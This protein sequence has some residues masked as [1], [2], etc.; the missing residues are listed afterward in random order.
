M[1]QGRTIDKVK[2]FKGSSVVPGLTEPW[3]EHYPFGHAKA[4]RQQYL[5][6]VDGQLVVVYLSLS[7]FKSKQY[8]ETKTSSPLGFLPPWVNRSTEGIPG[9]S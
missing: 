9:F 7:L 8:R 6:F 4:V 2:G 1:A 3:L 5:A